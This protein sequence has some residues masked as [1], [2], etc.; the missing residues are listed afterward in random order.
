MQANHRKK[1]SAALAI[2][3]LSSQPVLASSLEAA[4][5]E[6]VQKNNS[7]RSNMAGTQSMISQTKGQVASVQ[8]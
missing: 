6:A 5:S 2:V 3:M 4:R 7:I 8:A 1:L